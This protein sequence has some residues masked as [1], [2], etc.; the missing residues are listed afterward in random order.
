MRL[1]VIHTYLVVAGAAFAAA[2]GVGG[3]TLSVFQRQ[4]RAAA[5]KEAAQTLRHRAREAEL[6]ALTTRADPRL[7]AAADALAAQ[8]AAPVPD[9]TLEPLRLA[10]MQTLG[11]GASAERLAELVRQLDDVI[12]KQ[13]RDDDAALRGDLLSLLGAC[14]LALALIVTISTLAARWMKRQTGRLAM[15]TRTINER[16]R[17]GDL[18]ARLDGQYAPEFDAVQTALN[19]ALSQLDEKLER[20]AASANVIANTSSGL[21]TMSQSVADG[22]GLQASLFDR[23]AGEVRDLVTSSSSAH[24]E[25]QH[26]VEQARAVSEQANQ[27]SEAMNELANLMQRIATSSKDSTVIIDDIDELALQTNLVALNAAVEAA[28]AGASGKAFAVVASEVRDLAQRSKDASR[29]TQERLKEAMKLSQ[30][31][32][33]LASSVSGRFSSIASSAQQ[34]AQHLGTIERSSREQQAR[35][36]SVTSLVGEAQRVTEANSSSARQS[37]EAS[38]RLSREAE[39]LD[40]LV[41]TLAA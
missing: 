6:L 15:A 29:R 30:Q 8:L 23:T 12:E 16:M 28:R 9:A 37:A 5:T 38:Q 31:A 22:A 25:A 3:V 34:T 14:G 21:S 33:S 17:R 7:A 10:V 1:S 26:S 11:S 41:G 32:S 20:V 39:Q 19:D 4:A 27:A 24:D 2:G 35:L 18:S 36:T 13:R 40:G